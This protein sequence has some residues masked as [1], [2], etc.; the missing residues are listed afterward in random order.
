MDFDGRVIALYKSYNHADKAGCSSLILMRSLATG[1]Q[2]ALFNDGGCLC[3]L[4][5]L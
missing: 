4:G 2:M 1:L 3:D 5:W